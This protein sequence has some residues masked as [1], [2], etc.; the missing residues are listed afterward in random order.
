MGFLFK[1]FSHQVI[2]VLICGALFMLIFWLF[3]F[4]LPVLSSYRLQ[5][6][7]LLLPLSC[8]GLLSLPDLLFQLYSL[9][10]L[11]LFCFYS[12]FVTASVQLF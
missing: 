2:R 7:S 5:L 8:F 3:I 11:T 9:L 6:K 1:N 12:F 10:H 4:Q